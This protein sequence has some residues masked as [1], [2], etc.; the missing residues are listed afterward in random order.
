MADTDATTPTPQDVQSDA[1]VQVALAGLSNAEHAQVV[2]AW[3]DDAPATTSEAFHEIEMAREAE[4]ARQNAD[5]HQHQQTELVEQGRYAEAHDGA[6]QAGYDL[7]VA[8]DQGAHVDTQLA[9]SDHEAASLDWAAHHDAI[10]Q[11]D[12][13]SAASY[14]ESGHLD[15][16]AYYADQ[17]HSTASVAADYGSAGDHASYAATDTTSHVDTSSATE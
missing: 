5:A 7:Q 4:A 8:H 15:T 16:A 3:H 13:A 14:A 12:A 2:D 17:A 1:D 11:D 6:V 9:Q 10:A